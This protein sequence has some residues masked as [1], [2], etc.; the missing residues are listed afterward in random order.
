[1]VQLSR[2]RAHYFRPTPEALQP[3]ITNVLTGIYVIQ[4]MIGTPK[5]YS[6][7]L[8]LDSGSDET[9]LQC[10]GCVN[11][12]PLRGGSFNYHESK[13]YKAVS[14]N[15]PLCVPKIC[16]P[17][18]MCLYDIHYLRGPISKG[19]VSAEN[20]TFPDKGGGFVSFQGLIFGCG[21]D[22]RNIMFGGPLTSDNSIAGVFGIAAGPRSFLTQLAP[23]THM[24]FSYCLTSHNKAQAPYSYLWFGPDAMIKGD[25][26]TTPLV[27]LGIPRYYLVCTGISLSGTKLPI[28]PS[29]FQMNQDGSGGFAFD[30]GSAQT[31][32][33]KSAYKVL[34][35]YVSAYFER[36]HRYPI[37]GKKLPYDLCYRNMHAAPSNFTMP[38]MTYHFQGG[39]DLV[40][41]PNSVFQYFEDKETDMFCLVVLPH[42]DDAVPSL[43]GAYQQ[44][45]HR[46]LF[47]V[48]KYTV[49]F[50]PEICGKSN[51]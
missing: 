12:F 27:A 1:M 37:T 26:K 40:L 16:S 3:K 18:G 22:N 29:L 23:T 32:L 41:G 25:F 38:S 13:T 15:H 44:V 28:S 43:L 4:M 31:F 46:F 33:A 48:G 42:E 5:P 20:F 17:T 51:Q 21:F 24:R 10:D 8:L 49:S 50:I 47:D 6:T 30:T 9:W 14:C 36:Y 45:D 34:R 7:Y 39:A 19:I 2:T 11:C 35:T